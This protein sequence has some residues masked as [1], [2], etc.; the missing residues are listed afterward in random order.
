MGWKE[1]DVASSRVVEKETTRLVQ[2]RSDG[3]DSRNHPAAERGRIPVREGGG[4]EE[5]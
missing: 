5:I 1:V 4:R 2:P 3:S